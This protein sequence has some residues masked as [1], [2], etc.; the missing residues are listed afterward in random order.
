LCAFLDLGANEKGW[1]LAASVLVE[2]DRV[3]DTSRSEPYL[4]PGGPLQR[5]VEESRTSYPKLP[6]PSLL[7]VGEMAQLLRGAREEYS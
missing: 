3:H 1:L 2:L 7:P 6:P 5:L 4:A